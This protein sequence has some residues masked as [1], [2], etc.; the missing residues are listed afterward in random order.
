MT[1]I[2]DNWLKLLTALQKNFTEELSLKGVL[3]LIGVQELNKGVSVFSK[4]AKLE[5]LHIA[6]CTLLSP[7]GFF[8]FYK[9]D[10]EGWPHWKELKPINL[11]SE[12]EQ[13]VLLKKAIVNYFNK[14]E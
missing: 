9:I 5:V 10:S 14:H 2:E 13:E 3:F 6:I 7:Y 4:E 11:I 1:A 8:K 12:K